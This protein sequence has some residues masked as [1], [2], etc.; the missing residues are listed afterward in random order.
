MKANHLSPDLLAAFLDGRATSDETLE[1]LDALAT[2]PALRETLRISLAVDKEL[3]VK[4]T[5]GAMKGGK[6]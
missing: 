6:D 1:I 3:E 5:Y 2:D 4:L